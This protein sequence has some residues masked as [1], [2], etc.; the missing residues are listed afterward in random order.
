[1]SVPTNLIGRRAVYTCI[2]KH[3]DADRR[4]MVEDSRQ[5]FHGEIVALVVTG[6][7]HH[8]AIVMLYDDGS[9]REHEIG[10]ITIEGVH[11]DPFR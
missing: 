5:Q 1:M 11:G 6:E 10:T 9:L 4:D 8:A 7:Y 2:K 3:W